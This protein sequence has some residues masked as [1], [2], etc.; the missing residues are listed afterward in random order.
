MKVAKSR[1]RVNAKRIDR[2]NETNDLFTK[3]PNQTVDI[4]VIDISRGKGRWVM[5]EIIMFLVLAALM[6]ASIPGKAVLCSLDKPR[7][8]TKDKDLRESIIEPVV[9]SDHC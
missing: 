4:C 5:K 7:L 8:Q 6:F 3:N 1:A 9:E 2:N